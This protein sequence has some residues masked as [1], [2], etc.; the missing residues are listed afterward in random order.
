MLKILRSLQPHLPSSSFPVA[1]LAQH[2]RNLLCVPSRP[3]ASK[4][5]QL[6]T[7]RKSTDLSLS[8]FN[9]TRQAALGTFQSIFKLTIYN[10]FSKGDIEGGGGVGLAL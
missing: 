9:L 8:L 2:G 4:I 10:Q 1:S 6:R 7:A 3:T 5:S